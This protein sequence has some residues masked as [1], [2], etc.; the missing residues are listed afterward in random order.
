MVPVRESGDV[1]KAMERFVAV[2]AAGLKRRGFQRR[3]RWFYR[4]VEHA[5]HVVYVQGARRNRSARF[6]E[7]DARA[8]AYVNLWSYFPELEVA[9]GRGVVE[10]PK[11][12]RFFLRIGPSSDNVADEPRWQ[13]TPHEAEREGER[14]LARFD[15]L[16]EPWFE[17]MSRSASKPGSTRS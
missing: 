10:F 15:A 7:D 4:R 11:G 8:Y 9:E 3:G 14:L 17:A 6:F 1:G 5:V 16:G 13:F 12:S 2:S